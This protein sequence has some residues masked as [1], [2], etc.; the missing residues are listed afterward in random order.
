LAFSDIPIRIPDVIEWASKAPGLA[1][2][3]AHF[4][5]YPV[6]SDPMEIWISA[7]TWD[8]DHRNGLLRRI[9]QDKLQNFKALCRASDYY[10]ANTKQAIPVPQ[11]DGRYGGVQVAG[12]ER[13]LIL[14]RRSS[15]F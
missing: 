12:R 2:W 15:G 3:K 13:G 10:V 8:A 14:P 5:A 1:L 4:D 7:I 11:G 6:D 9:N